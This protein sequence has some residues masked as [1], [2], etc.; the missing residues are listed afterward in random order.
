MIKS[1]RTLSSGLLKE[2]KDSAFFSLS[3]RLSLTDTITQFAFKA[4]C[5]CSDQRIQMSNPPTAAARSERLPGI[6]YALLAY[7]SWGLFPLY[8]RLL[9]SVPP[10]ELVGI[11]IVLAMLFT[12]TLLIWVG[13]LKELRTLLT[14]PSHLMGVLARALLI[15]CN[16]YVYIG[17]V[18]SGHVLESSLGY[19]LNPL[20]NVTLG[21]LVLSE[22][23][24]RWQ[25]VAVLLAAVGVLF[26]ALNVGGSLWISLVLA[27]SFGLYA[28]LC[29]MSK[30]E[31]LVSL[32]AET[33]LLSPLALFDLGRHHEGV[34]ALLNSHLL[35]P[36]ALLALSG[37]VTSLP[38]WWFAKA[39]KRLPLSV[40]GFFQY[41][42]P[43][44]QFIMAIYLFHEPFS[45]AH[46]VTFGC[47]W[48]ALLLYSFESWYH[49]RAHSKN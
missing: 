38:M 39:A 37:V 28:L 15:G 46:I 40:M 42:G 32:G 47:I 5:Q 14:S 19:Y 25:L 33:L 8:W 36:L 30:A 16:W 34:S 2:R 12:T 17:A 22:R 23:L 31:P 10:R 21:V 7:G 29:K 26:F 13:K 3:T 49:F 24:R 11:R 48:S 6:R 43:S 27:S 20:I 18:N 44:M 45:R 41:I 9:R 1:K 4:P 35:L